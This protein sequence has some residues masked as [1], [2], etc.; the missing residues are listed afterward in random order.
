MKSLLNS[1]ELYFKNDPADNCE[2]SEIDT[3]F[4]GEEEILDRRWG[5]SE[6]SKI[7]AGEW[8][9]RVKEMYLQG[10]PDA[11]LDEPFTRCLAE[12]GWGLNMFMRAGGHTTNDNTTDLFALY[13]VL[14]R[15]LGFPAPL[16]L[17]LFPI[18]TKKVDL[19]RVA[20]ILGHI[21]CSTYCFEGG[22]NL[23]WAGDFGPER[24]AACMLLRVCI[25]HPNN[26]MCN[27]IVH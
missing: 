9:A 27:M 5:K 18:W 26:F 13:N 21:L 6:R 3:F 17:T 23:D 22:L 14:T 1:V 16:K 7:V 20:E 19:C 12:C 8:I 24:I 10:L 11:D 2:N 25:C 15:K 4:T